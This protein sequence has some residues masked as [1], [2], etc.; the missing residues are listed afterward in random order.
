MQPIYD[1][2]N[3]YPVNEKTKFR[4]DST[5]D[6][7]KTQKR[8]NLLLIMFSGIG[9]TNKFVYLKRTVKYI[10]L[11]PPT[12]CDSAPPLCRVSTRFRA[13]ACISPSPQSPSLKLEI[14]RNLPQPKTCHAQNELQATF[15]NKEIQTLY[16][17]VVY[18]LFSELIILFFSRLKGLMRSGKCVIGGETDEREKYIAPTVLTGVKPT[19]P[20]M[21]NEVT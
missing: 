13:R 21:E 6:L 15:S 5:K 2:E 12:D 11:T 16:P 8:G 7:Q 1:H 19:D 18:N 20:L 3:D 9:A 17:R 4:Q 14:T 10:N